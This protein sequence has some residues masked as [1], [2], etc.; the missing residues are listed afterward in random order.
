MK[1]DNS[2]SFFPALS[3]AW[4]QDAINKS[5][6]DQLVTHFGKTQVLVIIG[7]S[8]P[9][10]NRDID[11]QLLE[12]AFGSLQKIYIQDPNSTFVERRLMGILPKFSRDNIEHVGEERQF[13]IPP[14]L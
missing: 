7:Y 9:T 6:L 12:R 14:E 13:F 2:D 11:K 4:E 3:F 5:F 10:F 8:F 1:L